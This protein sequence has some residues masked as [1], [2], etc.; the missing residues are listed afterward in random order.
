MFR[1]KTTEQVN[2]SLNIK[3]IIIIIIENFCLTVH[4][5]SGGRFFGEFKIK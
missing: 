5:Q 4:H 1:S 3:V 2:R